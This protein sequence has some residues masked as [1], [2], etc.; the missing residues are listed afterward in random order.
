MAF[1]HLGFS[2]RKILIISVFI[3]AILIGGIVTYNGKIKVEATSVKTALAVTQKTPEPV[4]K[5]EIIQPNQPIQPAPLKQTEQEIPPPFNQLVLAQIST[6][7]NGSYPYLLN[8]DYAHYNGVTTNLYYQG[9]L[10]LRADP[11]GSHASHCVG[12]TFEVF[13]RAMEAWNKE[14][15]SAG[16]SIK[17][18]SYDRL[19]DFVLKWYAAGPKTENNQVI[20][21]KKYHL[22][23]QI[24]NFADARPG[25]F[26]D[27]SREN[28]TGHTVVLINWI[29]DNDKI[30][31]LRY[32]SS[33]ASTHGIAYK[34]EYF[35]I[36]R[37]DGSEYGNIIEDSV[38]IGRAVP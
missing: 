26:I 14:H 15:G 1:R 34:T 12:I 18:L 9:Q 3:T 11:A 5:A 25:D 29:R 27:F 33:Q 38:L 4:T 30:V 7:A 20:A 17:G 2:K 10:L 37:S 19:Y 23:K 21:L 6:Y 16:D 24:T 8:T 13:F 28:Q 36:R 22:G 32:W 35:N 31:G